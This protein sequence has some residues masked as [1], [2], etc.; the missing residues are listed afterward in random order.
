MKCI[1]SLGARWGIG[2]H[3]VGTIEAVMSGV[4]IGATE[5]HR[6]RVLGI[7]HSRGID[8]VFFHQLT[9]VFP[10]NVGLFGG[11]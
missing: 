11:V 4:G 2:T 9:E 10:V 8:F 3:D 7:H 5:S 6:L 1:R